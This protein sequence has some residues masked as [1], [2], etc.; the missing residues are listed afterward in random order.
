MKRNKET[1]TEGS[2]DVQAEL[3]LCIRPDASLMI[4][5]GLH[6]TAW[7]APL[8][9]FKQ[10]LQTDQTAT[11][12]LPVSYFSSSKFPNYSRLHPDRW[13]RVRWNNPTLNECEPQRWHTT[14][15]P[16][17]RQREEMKRGQET[18]TYL[19]VFVFLAW[20]PLSPLVSTFPFW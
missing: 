7:W 19:M 10:S 2:E 20:L 12:T 14:M 3:F 11:T 13:G 15:N 8:R 1:K 5:Q 17:V 18:E 4:R 9:N 6:V 16:E